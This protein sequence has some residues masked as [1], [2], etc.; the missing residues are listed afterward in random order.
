MKEPIQGLLRNCHLRLGGARK[1]HLLLQTP[2]F[3]LRPLATD[4][5]RNDLE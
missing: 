1:P 3:A 4:R 2:V 5:T